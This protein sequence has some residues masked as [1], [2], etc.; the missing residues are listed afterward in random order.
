MADEPQHQIAPH[1]QNTGGKMGFISDLLTTINIGG[2][3]SEQGA[4]KA[5]LTISQ[6]LHFFFKAI[7]TGVM[8]AMIFYFLPYLAEF[9]NALRHG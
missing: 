9:I 6:G 7:G 3:M 8:I 4:D 1:R 2:K 5:G